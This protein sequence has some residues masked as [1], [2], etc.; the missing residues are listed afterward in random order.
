MSTPTTESGPRPEF[1]LRLADLA[2]AD[3]GRAGTKAANLGELARASFPVPDGFVVSTAAFDQFVS[4]N[5]LGPGHSPEA[6]AAAPFPLEVAAAIRSAALALGGMPLAVRSPGTAEDGAE[7]SFAGQYQ[8]F[9]GVRG[10]EAVLDAVRRCWASALAS[11][12]VAYRMRKAPGGAGRMAVLVQRLVQAESAGVAFSANPV[13]GEREELVINAVR[14][15]GERLVSGQ[16]SP[17]EW[18][19]R[20]NQVICR[21]APEA[22]IDSSLAVAIAALARQ[23]ETHFGCPQ[24]IEW[25]VANGKV[26]VLQARPITTLSEQPAVQMLPVPADPPEGYWRRE[27]SHFPK[28]LSRMF[29]A[30]WMPVQNAAMKRQ[31]DLAGTLLEN[32]E[33]REI[34]GWVYSRLVPLGGKDRPTPPVI[35]LWLLL[36]TLPAMRART[37]QAR[38]VIRNDLAFRNCER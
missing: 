33:H 22:A 5:A 12:V 13:T 35:L 4:A 31:F 17:D 16:A 18:I 38:E 30:T 36:R 24:D 20:G 14:G 32:H 26:F 3:A 21:R 1:V 23:A 8:T 28:P 34:G 29:H 37:R 2:S 11:H 25:A 7:A 10:P 19:V 27:A 9:L 15:L 6:V